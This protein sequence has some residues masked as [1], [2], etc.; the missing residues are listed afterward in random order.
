MVDSGKH[1]KQFRS[2][3]NNPE[4][5]DHK[6]LLLALGNDIL[7]DDAV[8]LYAARELGK[9]FSGQIE[10]LEAPI[11]G[12]AL[13]DILHGYERVLIVD[14]ITSASRKPGLVREIAID[15]FQEQSF[16]SPHYVGLKEIIELAQK[17]EIPFPSEIRILGI[18]VTDPYILRDGLSPEI[19]AHLPTLVREAERILGG[20]TCEPAEQPMG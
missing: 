10:I 1:P 11:G 8:G 16:P 19:E 5:R 18:E 15:D 14:S 12:F 20:W 2:N 6:I 7:G 13:V 9:Q 17:L 3:N 4:S